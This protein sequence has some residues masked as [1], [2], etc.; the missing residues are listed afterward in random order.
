MIGLTS[1]LLSMVMAGSLNQPAEPEPAKLAGKIANSES[2][3]FVLINMEDNSRD[4]IKIEPNG[5]FEFSTN[6][7]VPSYRMLYVP[8][9]NLILNI[10]MENG[11]STLLEADLNNLAALKITGDLEPVYQFSEQEEMALKKVGEPSEYDDFKAYGIGLESVKNSLCKELENLKSEG[12]KVYETRNLKETLDKMKIQYMYYLRKIQK[13]L[14]S[15][16]DFNVFMNSIDLNDESLVGNKISCYI[17]WRAACR[18][19]NGN[20]NTL[21]SLLVIKDEIANKSIAEKEAL[22]LCKM[23]YGGGADN[24]IDEVYEIAKELLSE[25]SLTKIEP[26][27]QKIKAFAPG[28]EALDFEMS[29]PDGKIVKLSD[30]KGKAIYLDIWA[31][32]CGPCRK[33]IPSMAK[34]AEH[35]KNS[36]KVSII[37]ISVD[38][39]QKAWQKLLKKDQPQWPQFV[40]PGDFESPLLKLYGINGIPRFMMFDKEGRIVNINAPRPSSKDIV[41]YIDNHL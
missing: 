31:T 9:T 39:N 14:D 38:S 10:F 8:N 11:T 32:W 20:P 7:D 18:T 33:E 15:D 4:S 27:H 34:V 3:F 30:L 24:H 19:G 22:G 13:P 28:K 29:T 23:Y 40:V 26:I 1:F 16:A 37:S 12:F 41:E 21:E 36:D 5:V 17:N 35:Y 6:V 25:D 2:S